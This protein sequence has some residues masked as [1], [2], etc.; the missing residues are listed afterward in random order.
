MVRI[1]CTVHV[2]RYFL[3]IITVCLLQFSCTP[4][5]T[6]NPDGPTEE[7]TPLLKH[8]GS[9]RLS[10]DRAGVQGVGLGNKAFFAG[11]QDFIF[12]NVPTVSP[13]EN[14]VDTVDI[15]DDQSGSWSRT[16]LSIGRSQM[17]LIAAG[18]RVWFAGGRYWTYNEDLQCTQVID[19][20]HTTTNTWSH[21]SLSEPKYDFSAV[22]YGSKIFF[23][24]GL[25]YK[26]DQFCKTVDV[27]DTLTNSWEHR[28]IDRPLFGQGA[29]SGNELFVSRWNTDI[30]DVYN[31]TDNSFRTL[32]LGQARVQVATAA[33][34]NL[35]LFAG[36][37]SYM[38]PGYHRRVDIFDTQSG[39]WSADSLS[40]GRYEPTPVVIGNKIVFVGGTNTKGPFDAS[41]RIDIYD[42]STR[43]WSIDSLTFGTKKPA[44]AV[45]GDKMI[46]AS[47]MQGIELGGEVDIFEILR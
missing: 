1:S 19:I 23:V 41:K 34:G 4:D 38:A 33:A 25:S 18:N 12:V 36:G 21:D 20:Y 27:Y 13:P 11:G 5:E 30:V 28:V 44:V 9:A 46:V 47:A 26:F 32:Q 22:M 40:E 17:G 14:H 24:G 15:Y 43:R 42:V 39:T 16:N 6:G 45:V 2:P 31:L 3:F 35:V 8:I 37:S 10:N 7:D 29:V